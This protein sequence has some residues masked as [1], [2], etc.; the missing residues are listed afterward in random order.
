MGVQAS[1]PHR[2][3]CANEHRGKESF[4]L[5]PSGSGVRVEIPTVITRTEWTRKQAAALRDALTALLDGGGAS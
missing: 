2:V 4:R 1:E 3:E 5:S